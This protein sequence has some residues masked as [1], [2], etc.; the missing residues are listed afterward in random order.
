[1]FERFKIWLKR[2]LGLADRGEVD[3]LTG[4]DSLRDG[5]AFPKT[6]IAADLMT[7]APSTVDSKQLDELCITHKLP[8]EE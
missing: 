6:N 8:S 5:I 7:E 1:M 3:Y 4:A 2:L